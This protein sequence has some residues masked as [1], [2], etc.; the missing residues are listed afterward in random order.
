MLTSTILLASLGG[1]ISFLSTLIGVLLTLTAWSSQKYL[2]LK[3]SMDFAL[4]LMLSAVAF[5]LV[6]PA[7]KESLHEDL[8]LPLLGGFVG[9]AA[10][11]YL[12]KHFIERKQH[13][14]SQSS[15]Q[16]L[17]ALALIIHNFPEG[18]ASGASSAGLSFQ[19]A[20]P[21]LSSIALQNVPEG[22]LMVLCL[23]GIG[24]SQ[25]ASFWGGVTSGVVELIG[26]VVAGLTLSL[27]TNALPMIFM[28][29]GGAMFTSVT[30]ELLEKG[31]L[32]VILRKPEFVLGLASV[33]LI[34]LV[35]S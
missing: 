32:P 8:L 19:A 28:V 24:W 4:G 21:I 35:L 6:G 15:S 16:L 22:L 1:F 18:L 9:G 11:I 26:G 30:I 2:K 31:S 13:D 10:L 3:F 17:L 29:A 34:N 7:F 25:R 12:I 14:S 23:K 27:T 20:L 5:S 33:P